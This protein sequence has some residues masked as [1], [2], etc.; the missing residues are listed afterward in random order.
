MAFGGVAATRTSDR[1]VT[2]AASQPVTKNSTSNEEVP[3]VL[4]SGIDDLT[5]SDSRSKPATADPYRSDD[6]DNDEEKIESEKVKHKQIRELTHIYFPPRNLLNDHII[7]SR[8]DFPAFNE[9]ALSEAANNGVR[10]P[11]KVPSYQGPLS[12]SDTSNSR[13]VS[14]TGGTKLLLAQIR[15]FHRDKTAEVRN[16]ERLSAEAE[17]ARKDAQR[18]DKKRL[19]QIAI[20]DKKAATDAKKV[21][22]DAKKATADAKKDAKRDARETKEAATQAKK[23]DA[24]RAKA[25]K[26]TISNGEEPAVHNRPAVLTTTPIDDVEEEEEDKEGDKENYE[27]HRDEDEDHGEQEEYQDEGNEDEDNKDEGGDEIV[28]DTFATIQ[29]KFNHE[30]GYDD[31]LPPLISNEEMFKDL[32]K[33]LIRAGM[34]ELT[35]LMGGC[36][37]K[38]GT[39][40][41][42]TEAPILAMRILRDVFGEQGLIF[43]FEQVIS[44]EI[45]PAKSAFIERNFSPALSARDIT[46]ISQ[47]SAK[48]NTSGKDEW[49]FTTA[50]GG[51]A[52]IPGNLD[53]LIAGF[54][55]DDF[56]HLNNRRKN[57]N[58]NGESG[59]TFFA[60]LEYAD[61][62]RPKM[63]ILENVIK[64]PWLDAK[65]PH[66]DKKGPNPTI[67]LDK[68]F[69]NLDYV[70]CFMMLDTK[71]HYLPQTRQRGYMVCVLN[72]DPQHSTHLKFL[73]KEFPELVNKLKRPASV[74]MEALLFN[75]DEPLLNS[76]GREEGDV[77]KKRGA[78]AWEKCKLGHQEYVLKHGLGSLRPVTHWEANGSKLLPDFYKQTTVF[79][80]RTMDCIDIAHLRNILLKGIDDRYLNRFL[81][82]SQNVY[83][84][85]DSERSGIISCL[86]PNNFL[87]LTLR[88]SRVTGLENLITQGY[89]PNLVDT[90]NMDD[91]LLKDM[92]GNAMT[93]TVVGTFMFAALIHF[94]DS[95]NFS[96]RPV[97]IEKPEPQPG[98]YGKDVLES[99]KSHPTFYEPVSVQ[100]ITAL[101]GRTVR[102]CICEG[103][104]D[105]SAHQ[106]RQCKVCRATSCVKCGKNP[107]HNYENFDIERKQPIE[108]INAIKNSLPFQIDLTALLKSEVTTSL[109]Q[110]A[111]HY[112]LPTGFSQ[113]E[114]TNLLG[115]V[116]MALSSK[117]SLRT[118]RRAHCFQVSFD[119]PCAV[120]KLEVSPSGVEWLLYA[121]VPEEPLASTMGKYLRRNPI[122]RMRPT[123]D[124]LMKGL[125]EIWNPKTTTLQIMVTSSGLLEK[126]FE[127]ERGLIAF[128]TTFVYPRISITSRGDYNSK[129]LDQDIQGDYFLSSDCGQAFNS[130]HARESTEG[131]KPLLLFFNQ[132][133]PSRN[134][135]NF[136]FSF[137]NDVARK[138]YGEE[139]S[140]KCNM[141]SFWRKPTVT[142]IK[143]ATGFKVDGV[144]I[145]SFVGHHSEEIDICL[146]GHWTPL[147]GIQLGLTSEEMIS[148]RRLPSNIQHIPISC[149]HKRAV[150][151]MAATLPYKLSVSKYRWTLIN[152]ANGIS[153]YKEFQFLFEKELVLRGHGE[154]DDIWTP[155]R[156]NVT[157]CSSCAPPL[158]SM[159]W[160]IEKKPGRGCG[161]QIPVENPEQAASHERAMKTRPSA[162]DVMYRISSFNQLELSIAIDP[163]TLMHRATGSLLLN[164]TVNRTGTMVGS[165]IQTSYRLITD[166]GKK[167]A[168]SSEEFTLKSTADVVPFQ[169]LSVS[170]FQDLTRNPICLF[171]SQTKALTWMLSQERN[172]QP[173]MEQAVAEASVKEIGYRLEAK[174]TREVSVAGGILAHE[175][176]FGKT[177]LI[178]SLIVLQLEDISKQVKEL[179][180]V[181]GAIRT[182]ATLIL[183]PNHL[184][185]QWYKEAKRIIG[186]LSTHIL[187][188]GN[189]AQLRKLKVSDIREALI[190]IASWDV[191]SSLAYQEAYAQFSG[192]VPYADNRSMRAQREWHRHSAATFAANVETL[193]NNP[194]QPHFE[195]ILKS[196]YDAS[197]IETN[198]HDEYN[199]SKHVT[200]SNYK[201][202]ASKGPNTGEKRKAVFV[203]SDDWNSLFD[204]KSMA[205]DDSV[206][207]LSHPLLEMFHWARVVIDEHTYA[208]PMSGLL[209]EFVQCSKVWLLS[210]TPRLGGF[211]DIKAMASLFGIN[212]GCD[213]YSIMNVDAL[214]KTMSEFTAS[215]KFAM[216]Q[217][218]PTV[219]WQQ[220]R[221]RQAQ[222][223]LDHFVRQDKVDLS[224]ITVQKQIIGVGQTAAEKALYMELA[225]RV[226]AKSFILDAVKST[227]GQTAKH[228]QEASSEGEDG[229]LA[230]FLQ[231]S[232]PNFKN[233]DTAIAE[234]DV[235]E[236][237][238]KARFLDYS[239]MANKLSNELH[240]AYRMSLRLAHTGENCTQYDNWVPSARN[241]HY[242]DHDVTD[243]IRLKLKS[244]LTVNEACEEI[245]VADAL[246]TLASKLNTTC[247]KLVVR[248]RSLR[249]W[250][251]VRLIQQD[252]LNCSKCKCKAHA[253]DAT[254][255]ASCG[256]VVCSNCK[257]SIVDICG[258]IQGRDK[259]SA[260]S[261]AHQQVSCASL[262]AEGDLLQITMGSKIDC[263]VKL[264]EKK[265]KLGE[266]V[267]VFVQFSQ[268]QKKLEQALQA[269]HIKSAN[270]DEKITSSRTLE[271]FKDVSSKIRV[272]IMH[273]AAETAAGSN[274]TIAPNLVFFEPLYTHGSN[275]RQEYD[276]AMTQAIGRSRRLGQTKTVEVYELLATGTIEVDYKEHRDDCL[277]VPSNFPDRLSFPS[278]LK[279]VARSSPHDHGD[280]ASSLVGNTEFD[281]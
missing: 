93:A 159:Q 74:P 79:T 127:N 182:K 51:K 231:A 23:A 256:H 152:K 98:G 63:I 270:L 203:A 165:G 265:T 90:M 41:S 183:V 53:I 65:V 167:A 13:A 106:I 186:S 142:A 25:A 247:E 86:F 244:L 29:K 160:T 43:N 107:K 42:G 222:A 162:I 34:G 102:L 8:Y 169:S 148:Y 27:D 14:A 109:L 269:A 268:V 71:Q 221:M 6:D 104:F 55:C 35:K 56:S 3:D 141:P 9:G 151:E 76:T 242:G 178:L 149:G 174:A 266:K 50:Y 188:I 130:V 198:K 251:V 153:F 157:V 197:V 163:A 150:F 125:W 15:A 30:P 114:W 89:N 245:N 123:G 28:E 216:Y 273:T 234:R 66:N 250:D 190:V 16:T 259:C 122:A 133:V 92:S 238:Q 137:T 85:E 219:A 179:S 257:C 20:N 61:K 192:N 119:S 68:H 201:S 78:W 2:E 258:A 215:E 217:E 77:K 26:A 206:D 31:T 240:D 202:A 124:D 211:H 12:A 177:I 249:V 95:F 171:E 205:D 195:T 158:P 180:N 113:T 11:G 139:L 87:F 246:R 239:A 145:E 175:V 24:A 255:L 235:L 185:K 84:Y 213:D 73:A 49:V 103:Q 281:G 207:G 193:K 117:V 146:D 260:G 276:S 72:D 228:N 60:I 99:H 135:D 278:R 223:F 75:F 248:K 214:K 57:L 19:K 204:F 129:H 196:Q 271:Q 94:R 132:H 5:Y 194:N 187:V 37:L 226:I 191:C 54:C 105:V 161:K 33:A 4:M 111:R 131:Q 263:A 32:G 275:A 80:N 64:T 155:S 120:L 82:L 48:D 210:G 189:V 81:E 243:F 147:P 44:A 254:L 156:D 237:I 67:G 279:Q 277:L 96:G 112:P 218:S 128:Q 233:G 10:P 58:A 274:L 144:P 212:I 45:H 173:F 39:F 134:P 236:T 181:E 110:D 1:R 17:W 227:A 70:V 261:V 69:E 262:L 176:G 253:S 108:F 143:T 220:T 232:S 38:V 121:N 199:P 241:N 230:L 267:L 40:C 200:G 21:S 138:R 118:T 52:K 229:K 272:L 46:E 154:F 208:K 116:K 18:D 264:I 224:H 47:Q 22:R 126:S 172:P 184:V 62:Y 136:F 91:V 280:L 88:G 36:A 140:V 170:P 100:D 209:L 164:D 168:P 225:Q 97:Q 101:A 83:R 59:D 115:K 7:G 252:E 166:Q